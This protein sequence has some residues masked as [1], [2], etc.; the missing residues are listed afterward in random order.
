MPLGLPFPDRPRP[1]L[2]AALVMAAP[3][4]AAAQATIPFGE[5]AIDGDSPIEIIA[6]T[7]E[8]DQE[9]GT[10]TFTGEVMVSQDELRLWADVVR[11]EYDLATDAEP[12]GISLVHA[13]GNVVMVTATEAAESEEAVYDLEL[14]RI[15]MTGDVVLVQ[16]GSALAGDRLVWELERG[17]GRMDGNIRSV[18]LRQDRQ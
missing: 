2:L 17:A 12:G 9:E 4:V 5:I 8:V 11:V 13:I 10:A 1:W 14:G 15:T 18:I 16:G 6:E 7:L 3:C